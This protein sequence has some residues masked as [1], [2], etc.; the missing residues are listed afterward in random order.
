MTTR[1]RSD[2]IGGSGF[3]AM[4]MWSLPSPARSLGA[5]RSNRLLDMTGFLLRAECYHGIFPHFMMARPVAPFHG[6]LDDG[7]DLVETAFL[8]Q[9][10]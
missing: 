3:V 10:L 9:G 1:R 2:G 6:P 5:K 7:G 4:A 8:M